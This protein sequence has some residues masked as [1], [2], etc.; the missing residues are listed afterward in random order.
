MPQTPVRPALSLRVPQVRD[1]EEKAT[2]ETAGRPRQSPIAESGD[3]GGGRNQ[4]RRGLRTQKIKAIR[5]LATIACGCYPQVKPALLAAL[6][7]CTEE[8][9]FE[10]AFAFCRSAGNPCTVCNS[11]TCCDPDVRRKFCPA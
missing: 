11:S 7:D 4:D 9:R 6:D 10:A 2:G 8:V 3:Q 5:Y 1:L